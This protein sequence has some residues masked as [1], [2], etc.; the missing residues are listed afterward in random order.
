LVCTCSP[1][2]INEDLDRQRLA[3]K[4][5]DGLH[6]R[7]RKKR[8]EDQSVRLYEGRDVCVAGRPTRER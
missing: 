6:D 2:V 1:S 7:R 8:L 3:Y 5:V 4:V